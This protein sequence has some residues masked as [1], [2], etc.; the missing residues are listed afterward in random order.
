VPEY[1]RVDSLTRPGLKDP[2]YAAVLEEVVP[3]LIEQGILQGKTIRGKPHVLDDEALRRTLQLGIEPMV[4]QQQG[5]SFTAI[6]APIDDVLKVLRDIDLLDI[7]EVRQDVEI[8]PH[9]RSRVTGPEPPPVRPLFLVKPRASDW[10]VLVIRIHWYTPAD[11]DIA[12]KVAIECSKRLKTRA[13]AAFD[14]DV[15]GSFAKEWR[16]GRGGEEWSTNDATDDFYLKFYQRQIAGPSS[17]MTAK[18]G[19]HAF[20]SETPDAIERVDYI[21]VT[22][23]RPKPT[24]KKRAQA[25]D[26]GQLTTGEDL[27]RQL[28]LAMGA[29]IKKKP[30]SKNRPKKR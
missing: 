1:L 20:M 22:E 5:W 17:W 9:K 16:N 4:Y 23:P 7:A 14:D 28:A 18:D 27:L 25:S 10:T 12:A 26:T 21:G 30:S 11:W 19:Q 29:P 15:A 6:E 8:L 13:V 2:Y 3:R 24:P